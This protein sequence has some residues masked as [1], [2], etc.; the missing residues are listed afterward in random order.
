LKIE[1]VRFDSGGRVV[2]RPGTRLDRFG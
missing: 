1:G 2:G